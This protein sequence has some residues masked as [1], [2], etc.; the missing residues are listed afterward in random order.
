MSEADGFELF[1]RTTQN[2]KGTADP[3]GKGRAMDEE[4][5]EP[6]QRP[7]VHLSAQPLISC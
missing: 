4:A 2:R 7:K 1:K 5:N 3:K 6:E